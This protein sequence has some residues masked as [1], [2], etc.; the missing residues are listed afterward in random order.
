VLYPRIAFPCSDKTRETV[1]ETKG[2]ES[3]R[4]TIDCDAQ[5]CSLL[6]AVVAKS[7]APLQVSMDARTAAA[8]LAAEV[9]NKHLTGLAPLPYYSANL[10]ELRA[11]LP[12]GFSP[13]L[14]DAS[15]AWEFA[16]EFAGISDKSVLA[17]VFSGPQAE[18]ILKFGELLFRSRSIEK[19]SLPAHEEAMLRLAHAQEA[20]THAARGM[21]AT[22]SEV[23]S[24]ARLIQ[25]DRSIHPASRIGLSSKDTV[26]ACV[27]ASMALNSGRSDAFA[28]LATESLRRAFGKIGQRGWN[29]SLV[30]RA[31]RLIS[32]SCIESIG[33]LNPDTHIRGFIRLGQ[34]LSFLAT[35]PIELVCKLAAQISGV[36]DAESSRRDQPVKETPKGVLFGSE[37]IEDLALVLQGAAMQCA[38]RKIRGWKPCAKAVVRI[39]VRTALPSSS[40]IQSSHERAAI[41]L[42]RIVPILPAYASQ[43]VASCAFQA[44]RSRSEEQLRM[45]VSVLAHVAPIAALHQPD[46]VPLLIVPCLSVLGQG[47]TGWSSQ[48]GILL[49]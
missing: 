43:L 48:V 40:L 41:A 34:S 3:T 4:R 38:V 35:G 36:L 33:L 44:S 49:S 13:D 21:L 37:L 22:Q 17:A 42:A 19:S 12:D 39:L 45:L 10:S 1:S 25:L 24:V 28:P 5:C 20:A 7:R 26:A 29:P 9:A 31:T 15:M 30:I 47:S 16:C 2:N 8:S 11:T 46:V 32:R 18:T 27:F 14:N 23:V 6:A